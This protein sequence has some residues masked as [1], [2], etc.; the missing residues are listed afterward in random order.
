MPPLESWARTGQ[1]HRDL[2]SFSFKLPYFPFGITFLISTHSSKAHVGLQELGFC[3]K[4]TFLDLRVAS[5][6][7]DICA[8]ARTRHL[9][10]VRTVKPV[11]T[12][13]RCA[14]FWLL[15][16]M[17]YHTPDAGTSL[18]MDMYARMIHSFCLVVLFNHHFYF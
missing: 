17:P 11:R 2:P 8:D 12:V 13:W 16:S 6:M 3:V 4:T 10:L 18:P 9:L 15:Y 14:L 7:L 5:R 1:P